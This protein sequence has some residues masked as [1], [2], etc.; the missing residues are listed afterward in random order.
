MSYASIQGHT[1]A[2]SSARA[3]SDA[4]A[5]LNDQTE[6]TLY[7]CLCTT[8]A[9]YASGARFWLGAALFS[10]FETPCVQAGAM[11]SPSTRAIG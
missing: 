6:F 8:S 3:P 11:T 1:E 9:I 5:C 10:L 2:R 4:R 7:V